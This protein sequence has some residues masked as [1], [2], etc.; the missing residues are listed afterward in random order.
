M[1]ENKF[2]TAENIETMRDRLIKSY[3]PEGAQGI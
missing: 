1:T 2:Q 3:T